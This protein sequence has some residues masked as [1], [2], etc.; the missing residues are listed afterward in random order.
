MAS[1]V[2]NDGQITKDTIAVLKSLNSP[3]QGSATVL[4]LLGIL[5]GVRPDTEAKE[6]NYFLPVKKMMSQAGFL[7]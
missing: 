6:H 1:P 3:S 4:D 5:F 7:K 2:K